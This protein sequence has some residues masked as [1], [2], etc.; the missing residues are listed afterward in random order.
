MNRISMKIKKLLLIC[1]ALFCIIP[2]VAEGYDRYYHDLPVALPQVTQPV[3]PLRTVSLADYGGKGDGITLNTDAFEQAIRALAKEGGGRLVV[4]AGIFL[5]GPIVLKGGIDLHLERNAVI[6]FSPDKALTVKDGDKKATAL[7]TAN[8]QQNIS[9]SGEGILDGNG[10]W[11]RPVKRDKV[12]DVEWK[13]YLSMG[14]TVTDQGSLWYPFRLK[15][16]GNIASTPEA[17]EKYRNHMIRFT[18]CD[19]VLVQGVTIMNSPKFHLTTQ[20]C[21]NVTIDGTTIRCPWN[22]QN[23]DGIDIGNSRNVLIVGNTIDCGDDGICMKGGAG[24]TGQ[25]YGPCKNIL[26]QDNTVYHAHGGFVIG[27]EF[28]GGMKNIVV[29]NNTFMGTET[30]LRFKSATGKGG[31]T[32]RI[33]I[34]H[35]QMTDIKDA[36]IVFETTYQDRPAGSKA[37]AA[38]P[39]QTE[40]VPEFQDIHISDVICRGTKT[41]IEAHG[42]KGMVHH[43]SVRHSTFFYTDKPMDIG[44]DCEISL[45]DVQFTTFHQ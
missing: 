20:R 31:K 34:S 3:I 13:Q 39:T 14:G 44:K 2:A 16:Y 9:I 28:S 37:K 4:P 25:G 30:G 5:T 32:E 15:H 40:F 42:E 12:S 11:W 33:Y 36:A 6:V 1:H 18:D 26:I 21:T 23:G 38:Q 10:E 8:K 7:I 43:I 22:A 27:S 29:R 41:G 17:Q 19:R 24:K 45:Q 35:I